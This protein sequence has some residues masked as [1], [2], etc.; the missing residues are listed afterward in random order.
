[1]SI[2]QL[3]QGTIAALQA[4]GDEGDEWGVSAGEFEINGQSLVMF[5]RFHPGWRLLEMVNRSSHPHRGIDQSLSGAGAWGT[6]PQS[7]V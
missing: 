6:T 3:V 1:M 4:G 7:S 5:S 2:L